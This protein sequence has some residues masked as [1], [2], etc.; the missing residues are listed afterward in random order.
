MNANDKD[1]IV[2]ALPFL[3]RW[4]GV[5]RCERL[6]P[7]VA[8][9]A[10]AAGYRVLTHAGVTVKVR[11]FASRFALNRM[12]AAHALVDAVRL[13]PLLATLQRTSIEGWVD[14]RELAALGAGGIPY[15]AAGDWLGRLHA[16]G[17]ESF[18]LSQFGANHGRALVQY[19]EAQFAADL[20]LLQEAGYCPAA[21]ARRID[22]TLRRWRPDRARAALIHGDFK[23]AHLLLDNQNALCSVDQQKLRVDAQAFDLGRVRASWPM[24]AA[25]WQIFLAAYARHI[26]I[27]SF[28]AH[29]PYWLMQGLV[30]RIATSLRQDRDTIET[31]LQALAGLLLSADER[32]LTAPP[33][34]KEFATAIANRPLACGAFHTLSSAMKS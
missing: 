22:E 24:D 20:A 17:S 23:P 26:P 2:E 27:E 10:R 14:G 33:G 3:E 1:N 11:C 25:A 28:L 30:D 21:L 15:A 13:T 32:A 9:N 34:G 4:G 18:G 8:L 12:A 29:A 6:A 5:A 31:P 7:A 16:S 19:R